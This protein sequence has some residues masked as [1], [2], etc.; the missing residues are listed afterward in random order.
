MKEL[1]LNDDEVAYKI[2]KN[3]GIKI[4]LKAMETNSDLATMQVAACE[5]IGFLLLKGR[6]EIQAPKL[7]KAIIT[8]MK[9]HSD[10]S[11]VQIHAC[12][13][14][15][16]LSQVPTT[17]LLLKKKETQELL[18]RAKSHFKSCESDVDDIITA[19]KK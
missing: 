2:V 4:I 9:N 17:R 7:A 12:D 11:N 15:F 6:N 14:L 13:A 16:E 8:A 10:A 19:C 3:G 18:L 5:V 1:C